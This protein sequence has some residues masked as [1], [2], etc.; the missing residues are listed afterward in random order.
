MQAALQRELLLPRTAK[1][2]PPRPDFPAF[3]IPL[4]A[5]HR[6]KQPVQSQETGRRRLA[7]GETRRIWSGTRERKRHDVVGVG[8]ITD[9]PTGSSLARASAQRKKEDDVPFSAFAAAGPAE[10][11][12]SPAM[13]QTAGKQ[14]ER[15]RAPS[16]EARAVDVDLFVS[17]ASFPRASTSARQPARLPKEA[18]CRV[19]RPSFVAP[20]GRPCASACRYAFPSVSSRAPSCCSLHPPAVNRFRRC[21]RRYGVANKP[22]ESVSRG[23]A[24][25]ACLAPIE[26]D[27]RRLDV[28]GRQDLRGLPTWAGLESKVHDNLHLGCLVLLAFARVAN[29]QTLVFLFSVSSSGPSLPLFH[30]AKN[31]QLSLLLRAGVVYGPRNPALSLGWSDIGLGS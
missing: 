12:Q 2:E 19:T 8:C 18:T 28:F 16:M 3:P 26:V 29:F 10:T 13:R 25:H 20:I 27:R 22:S 9:G 30:E 6:P 1:R 11:N 4:M 7:A 5:S 24:G 14:T 17:L 31:G 15:E 23:S 21:P